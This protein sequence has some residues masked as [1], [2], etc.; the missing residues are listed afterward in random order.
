[1]HPATLMKVL[2][3]LLGLLSSATALVVSRAPLRP[4][5]AARAPAP[6]AM[7]GMDLPL[8]LIA[9]I[10]DTEGERMYG[11]VD[12]PGWVLPLLATLA[13][14]TSLLPILLSPGEEAFARPAMGFQSPWE[15][16]QKD[17]E[18]IQVWP[19]PLSVP[20]RLLHPFA[21]RACPPRSSGTRHMRDNPLPCTTTP[22]HAQQP[23]PCTTTP[24]LLGARPYHLC[25][26][27]QHTHLPDTS[28]PLP[29]PAEK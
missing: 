21:R 27:R 1:M 6:Q 16:H 5:V 20:F 3:A 23:L 13:I 19:K 11:S 17:L 4:L 24:V 26:R 18:R 22:F 25:V 29:C 28:P 10:V 14:L 9:E 7:L 12:A 15:W 2:V 8:S